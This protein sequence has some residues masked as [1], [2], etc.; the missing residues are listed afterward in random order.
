MLTYLKKAIGRLTVVSG[1]AKYMPPDSLIGKRA[2]F[3]TN[4]KP[5]KLRGIWTVAIIL[6]AS[7][8]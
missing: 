2:A 1:L 8:S 7:N 3:I 4:I 6:A 5:G